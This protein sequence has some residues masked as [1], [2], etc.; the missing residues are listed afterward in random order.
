MRRT[1]LNIGPLFDDLLD[2]Y[3]VEQWPRRH[4]KAGSSWPGWPKAVHIFYPAKNPRQ[5][6]GSSSLYKRRL[7]GQRLTFENLSLWG[8]LTV[9]EPL[10]ES[11]VARVFLDQVR[12]YFRSLRPVSA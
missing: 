1:L 2:L 5:I 8:R 11:G 7:C 6:L 10:Q 3:Q 4:P 12:F 9:G